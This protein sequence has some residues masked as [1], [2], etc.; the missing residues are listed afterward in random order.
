MNAEQSVS[1]NSNTQ[2]IGDGNDIRVSTTSR[3]LDRLYEIAGDYIQ[4]IRNAQ[5][6]VRRVKAEEK[7]KTIAV[8]EELR[9]S[10][11]RNATEDCAAI[12]SL[13]ASEIGLLYA[14]IERERQH[15]NNT[16]KIVQLAASSLA[17]VEVGNE[18]P[19]AEWVNQFF[20][21]CKS[22]ST[23]QMQRLWAHILSQKIKSPNI[24][25]PLTL[26]CMRMLNRANAKV[27]EL[28]CNMA[29]VTDDKVFVLK[30]MVE[31]IEYGD[32]LEL[33]NIGLINAG[34]DIWFYTKSPFDMFPRHSGSV[35]EITAIQKITSIQKE[36]EPHIAVI[37]FTASGFELFGLIGQPQGGES[38][39]LPRIIELLK[40]H[41]VFVSINSR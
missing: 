10:K 4:D 7:A 39:F 1:G 37:P 15:Q 27:F 40:Q 12:P 6:I 9:R 16:S 33:E 3:A 34:K 25:R 21:Y 20:D 17:D 28:L 14:V 8:R 41:G 24:G 5:S 22:V 30:E 32:L 38:S 36:N 11:L 31:H 2:I 35:I 26:H 18:V 29:L 19:E 13:S 23:E